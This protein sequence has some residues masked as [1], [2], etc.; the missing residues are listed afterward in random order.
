V[1]RQRLDQALV[2]RGHVTSLASAISAIDE[3][4]VLVGGAVAE[5]AGRQVA[6]DEAIV[7]IDAPSAFVSRGGH[8]LAR[9]ID[10][11]DV[12]I[13]GH[14]AI[15]AGSATGGF[16]DCLLQAGATKVLAVDVGYGQLHE[17]LRSDPR[18]VSRERTNI[19]DL[20]RAQ[21][22]DLF[23]PESVP[24]LVVADL[25]FTSL[26]GLVNHLCSLAGEGGDLV[27]LC[28]PQFEVER[29]IASRGRGVVKDRSSR[30]EAL[31]GVCGALERAGATIM[32]VVS[33]PI[34][35]PAGNAEFLIHAVAGRVPSEL[36]LDEVLE[37]ALDD[38]ETLR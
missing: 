29:A 23:A 20:S 16:T 24:G 12:E 4:R 27:L 13:S 7:V 10:E 2:E 21:L 26:C 25:S 19:R 30:R 5:K 32:G 36:D 18:V 37:L 6:S 14:T 1:A 31:L 38:A 33:S 22:V 15:D 9:G 8:K 35:G 17:R 3:H 11:F 28:K 34:L